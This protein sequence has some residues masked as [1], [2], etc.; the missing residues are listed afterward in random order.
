MKSFKDCLGWIHLSF[1]TVKCRLVSSL[2]SFFMFS[3]IFK[4]RGELIPLSISSFPRSSLNC[5]RWF[6]MVRKPVFSSESHLLGM[7]VKV[8]SLPEGKQWFLWVFFKG[9]PVL[10]MDENAVEGQTLPPAL[11]HCTRKILSV[12]SRKI[13]SLSQ[14]SLL[15][16]VSEKDDGEQRVKSVLCIN[17]PLNWRLCTLWE[18]WHL[19]SQT[20]LCVS[21]GCDSPWKGD[22]GNDT[23]SQQ[24]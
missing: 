12:L 1:K 21:L 19:K 15:L 13:S 9:F 20:L 14:L 6:Y 22:S 4:S 10:L 18:L 5:V 24:W 11:P 17:A 23:S 8:R 2:I 3:L 16:N 7:S